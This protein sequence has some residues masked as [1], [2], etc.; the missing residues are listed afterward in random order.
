MLN[1]FMQQQEKSIQQSQFSHLQTL[2]QGTLSIEA[3]RGHQGQMVTAS[4]FDN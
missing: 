4:A 1:N 3:Q 2:G